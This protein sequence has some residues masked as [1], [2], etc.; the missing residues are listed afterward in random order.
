M[1]QSGYCAIPNSFKANLL[2]GKL[3]IGCWSTLTSP[4]TAEIL[5]L[6]GFDWIAL[7]TE[8]AP[9]DL[10]SL[11]IQLMALKESVSAPVVRPPSNDPVVIKRLLDV[12]FC[13]I[14]VPMVET[15]EE[16][17][18]AVHTTRYPPEGVR[19]VSV[20]MRGNRYGTTPDYLNQ[21]NQNITVI[22]QIESRKALENIDEILKVGGIDALFIGPSDLAA[23]LGHLGNISHHEVQEA[24]SLITARALAVRKSVGIFTS[25]ETDA[26]RY[27]SMGMNLVAVGSD[28]SLLRKSTQDLRDRFCV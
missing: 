6:A 1:N 14:V 24:I 5:G 22:A 4:I 8:H 23:D 21:I 27:I 13:N 28:Q 3:Q 2:S 11:L 16:A 19:G 25:S 17:T 18:N 7:D 12:G 9:N 26:R 10:N 15:A 20:S